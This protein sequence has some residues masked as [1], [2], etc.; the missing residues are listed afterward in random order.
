MDISRASAL[1]I[2][3]GLEALATTRVRVA[4]VL[5]RARGAQEVSRKFL[6]AQGHSRP[7]LY[8][9]AVALLVRA[10]APPASVLST[11]APWVPSLGVALWID[12]AHIKS[13][14]ICAGAHIKSFGGR[15]Y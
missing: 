8:C 10:A 3:A 6:L 9:G 12:G 7:L 5:T 14:D 13:L 1:W 15:T 11:L 2:S 4:G